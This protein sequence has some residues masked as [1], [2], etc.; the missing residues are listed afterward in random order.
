MKVYDETAE[1][2]DSN[3]LDERNELARRFIIRAS[4]RK[5]L[6][7]HAAS[8][9]IRRTTIL[10]P[11]LWLDFT[12]EIAGLVERAYL[13]GHLRRVAPKKGIAWIWMKA[14][15][16]TSGRWTRLNE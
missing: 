12:F 7:R 5:A 10:D 13:C 8:E 14:D 3:V 6:E 1:P 9:R 4:A 2:G 11:R 15:R 16:W